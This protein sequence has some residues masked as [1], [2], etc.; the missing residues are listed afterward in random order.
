[1]P[2]AGTGTHTK[3]ELLGEKVS[4]VLHVMMDL[5]HKGRQVTEVKEKEH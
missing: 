1:M 3:I 5:P 4:S 2:I